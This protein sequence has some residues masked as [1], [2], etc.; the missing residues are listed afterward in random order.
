MQKGRIISVLPRTCSAGRELF[1]QQTEPDGC[2]G[3]QSLACWDCGFE[4]HRVQGCL[5]VVNVACCA[6]RNLCDGLITSPE[7]YYRVCVCEC[8]CV[9]VCVCEG[10]Y[11]CVYKCVWGR[12]CVC[13][14]VRACVDVWVRVWLCV[15]VCVCVCVCVCVYTWLWSGTTIVLYTYNEWVEEAKKRK[16]ERKNIAVIWN[17]ISSKWQGNKYYIQ[18]RFSAATVQTDGVQM[19]H[20]KD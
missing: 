1:V 8:V 2:A 4:F 9:C 13:V 11:V 18:N 17:K 16:K 14:C 6:G 5:S 15:W 7:E 19:C 3:L 10:V 20:L 12:A